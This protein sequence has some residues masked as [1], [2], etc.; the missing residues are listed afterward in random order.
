MYYNIGNMAER[1]K[2]QID[3]STKTRARAKVVAAE[4]ELTLTELVLIALT[5]LGDTKL[6][7]LVQE[8]LA[9]RTG[10]GRPASK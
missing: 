2:L 4:R 1:I 6:T 3:I 8:D 10:R 5:K 7:K 9:D